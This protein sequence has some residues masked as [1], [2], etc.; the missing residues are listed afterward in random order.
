MRL[1]ELNKQKRFRL[2]DS[3]HCLSRKVLQKT[4]KCVRQRL[5]PNYR[6]MVLIEIIC[7]NENDPSRTRTHD[8]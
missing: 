6:K 8:L 7:E 5:T 2:T 1:N 3:C 4:R